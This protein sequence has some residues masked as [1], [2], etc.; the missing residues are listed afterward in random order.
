MIIVTQNIHPHTQ[1]HIHI[2]IHTHTVTH[3][4]T[5]FCTYTQIQLHIHCIH[6]QFTHTQLHTQFVFKIQYNYRYS[7]TERGPVA[8]FIF[9]D[10]TII[11]PGSDKI[12]VEGM[13]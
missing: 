7:I 12:L 3:T 4:H 13:S 10:V 11:P 6:A 2:H 5:Q 1:L 8:A 9:D